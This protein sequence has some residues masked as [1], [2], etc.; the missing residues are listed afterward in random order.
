LAD[1]VK[2][3]GPRAGITACFFLFCSF[4]SQAADN[5]WQFDPELDKIHSLIINLQTSQ[6]YDLLAHTAPKT[7]DL[8][9]LY[10]QSLCETL[11]IL[12]TEDAKRFDAVETKFKQRL[13][14]L[15][16]LPE[17]GETLFLQAEL[18]LQLGFNYLNL[19]QELNAVIAIKRAYNLVQECQKKFP[20]FVPIKKTS[21]VIQVMV[22]SVPDKYR[23]FMSL[24][25]M[26]GSVLVGQ[27]QLEELKASKSS[28]NIEATI[29]YYT[30][31]GLI[32]Q[33][34]DEASKGMLECLKT[35]PENRMLMFLAMEMLVKNSQ[36]EEALKLLLDLD[37]H[38]DGL[39]IYLTE[40][41]RGE[42]LLERGDYALAI[43]AYQKFISGYRSVSLKKD[44]YY[45]IALCYWLLNKPDL[46]KQ[47]FEKA[48]KTGHE[49]AEPD[50]YAAGQL[51]NPGFPNAKILKVRFYTDG[52]Y[53]KEA[54]ETL[55]SII[56]SD[57]VTFKDKTE[58]YYR[59]ARLA[60]KTG[61]LSAAKLF[62]QQS[63]DMT[64]QNPWYFAPNAALQ[65]G[66]IA[67][68]QKDYPAAR[69]YFEKALSY[70]KHEYKN[71]IDS[72]A[73]SALEQIPN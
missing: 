68:A 7:N 31:E 45:K 13:L 34:F 16:E 8:H 10:L 33:Q 62:Y 32:N 53:Y 6:A 54:R 29:L 64:G 17:R 49:T 24:L 12:F 72:K 2:I 70:K 63:I 9:K 57:L 71:S 58:Y 35:A 67:Q 50:K 41:W 28:M 21:G 56:P 61:E 66:Y 22:G 27:H 26:K 15:E 43:P 18:N 69:R 60:H 73:K 3:C 46:A 30:I 39:Q 59:K 48:K 11:D 14:Y 40:Y 25:G 4:S 65:L 51:E 37:E 1:F 36:G 5:V 44:S 20:A 52:G 19:S 47:N 55:H 42:I 38:A 23:W